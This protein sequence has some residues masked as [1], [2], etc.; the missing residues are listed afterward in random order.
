LEYRDE[1]VSVLGGPIEDNADVGTLACRN[2]DLDGGGMWGTV[3]EKNH[4]APSS[5][6]WAADDIAA[7]R[8]TTS[9][10]CSRHGCHQVKVIFIFIIVCIHNYET[11]K[12]SSHLPETIPNAAEIHSYLIA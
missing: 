4:R 1:F 3:R 11:N 8:R 2:A 7:G 12:H 5:V 9:G 6:T 10:I